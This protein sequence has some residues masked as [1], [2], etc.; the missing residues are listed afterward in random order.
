MYPISNLTNTATIAGASRVSP[1]TPSRE[2]EALAFLAER[3]AHTFAMAG[4]IRENGALS[5]HNRGTF[6]VS[7]NELGQLDGIA[8]IG[9]NTLF[10]ARSDSALD[11][12]AEIAV[13]C[14]NVFRVL[15]EWDKVDRFM[16]PFKR[17]GR[18]VRL[19]CRE[20]LFEKRWPVEI[21]DPIPGL[22]LATPAELD[23]VA[24]VHAEMAFDECGVNPMEK[25]PVGFRQRCSRR[26]QNAKTFVWVE[27]GML[28][29]KA[30]IV[31]QTPEVVYL[32]GIW[33]NPSER[34]KDK[35]QRCLS[36]LVRDLLNRAPSVILMVNQKFER[37]LNFYHKAGFKMISYVDTVY[38]E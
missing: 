29:F 26:I 28:M 10:E 11:A 17:H 5:P 35:G 36:Q 21:L 31:A 25:D 16:A 2:A 33:V 3:P 23:L 34:G 7:R 4:W 32:E 19:E 8:L 20:H 18:T 22:R 15:G 38:V 6:F 1:L 30:E 13:S 37:A 12:F 9:H 27:D 14:P 24:P